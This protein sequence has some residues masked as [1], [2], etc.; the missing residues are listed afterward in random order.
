MEFT[1]DHLLEQLNNE[2]K[3][4]GYEFSVIEHE[5]S[6]DML[7]FNG[8]DWQDYAVGYYDDEMPELLFNASL[9]VFKRIMDNR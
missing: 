7:F 5:E 6:L 8:E 1:Y 4:Y 9:F 2:I 3:P